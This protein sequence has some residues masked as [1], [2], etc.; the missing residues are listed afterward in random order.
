[1]GIY[2]GFYCPQ[3][4]KDYQHYDDDDDDDYYDVN[5]A[6]MPMFW[7]ATSSESTHT[8]KNP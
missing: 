6:T 7:S 1:M 4:A 3:T 2:G 8:L 5:V